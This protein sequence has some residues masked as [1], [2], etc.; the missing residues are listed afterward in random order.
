[1]NL[2]DLKIESEIIPF[3]DIS[4][5]RHS[6]EALA[7]LF[8]TLPKSMSEALEREQV[9]QGFTANLGKIKV[10]HSYKRDLEESYEFCC[11]LESH[12]PVSKM[13]L[14]FSRKKREQLLSRS[15]QLLRMFERI[16]H[17]YFSRLDVDQF[18]PAYKRSIREIIEP[19]CTFEKEWSL[20]IKK[21][22]YLTVSEVTGFMKRLYTLFKSGQL[23]KCWSEF[24]LFEAYLS[25]ALTAQKA[26]LV[27]A[28]FIDKG[29]YLTNFFHPFIKDPVKNSIHIEKNVL[30]LTGPNMSGKST[31]LRAISL[32]MYLAR[33]GLPVPAGECRVVFAAAI[34]VFINTRDSLNSGYSH[35]M[36]EVLNLKESII[37]A[38][39]DKQVFTVFD[40][41]FSGTNIDDALNILTLTLNG[42]KKFPRS[43][44]LLSTHFYKLKELQV[45]EMS[46]AAFYYIDSLLEE[47]NPK[48]IYQLKE[49]WSDVK[50]GTLLFE[51][52]G[53]VQLLK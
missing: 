42:L 17:H 47:G 36:T 1:L 25:I 38:Q 26:G 3:F 14:R 46:H 39:E 53:L 4:L 44:F 5:N 23:L 9:I 40:E 41:M 37:A 22:N 24:F 49:G 15:I 34:N 48:F 20:L 28:Q 27:P 12:L 13:K 21:G 11:R 18:P 52:E 19:I 32:C 51:R 29:I 7:S 43:Y 16:N 50:F 2:T 31:L 30:V 35:F 8:H 33:L 6:R 10:L 45:D